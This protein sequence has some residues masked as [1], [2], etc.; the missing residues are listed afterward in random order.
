FKDQDALNI[1]FADEWLELDLR[2][3]ATGL[4]TYAKWS[5]PDRDATW[6]HGELEKLHDDPA[7]V[8]FTGPVHPEMASVLNEYVQ[9]WTSKPWGY[10]G[11]PG[12][13]FTEA[14]WSILELTAWAGYRNSSERLI[15]MDDAR[16]DAMK[17]GCEAFKKAVGAEK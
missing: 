12:N 13:P 9:P 16:A 10:G 14:W 17:A 5:A 4:G 3:N 8:H 15:A 2:W 11:A 7:I 6:S 1:F